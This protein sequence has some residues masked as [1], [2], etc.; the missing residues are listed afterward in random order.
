MR[1]SLTVV[2]RSYKSHKTL[3]ASIRSVQ[4]G[5]KNLPGACILGV[6]P[7]EDQRTTKIF[8]EHNCKVVHTAV[9]DITRQANAGFAAADTEFVQVFDSDDIMYP[10]MSMSSFYAGVGSDADIIYTDYEM[11][12]GKDF[13]EPI[14]CIGALNEL[15]WRCFIPELCV[16]RREP[17]LRLGGFDEDLWRYAQWDYFLRLRNSGGSFM[18]LPF[19][20]FR[21][22]LS[23]AQLSRRIDEGEFSEVDDP[24][25]DKFRAKH[26][27]MPRAVTVG[28]GARMRKMKDV[29]A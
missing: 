16:F 27:G 29:P 10:N 28:H 8:K 19:F 21:Y 9:P 1:Q 17:W 15:D 26:G 4:A 2:I 13:L 23:K 20:G 3:P 22:C 5:I 7:I 18:R 25:W 6:V 14:R 11:W 12:E 24:A